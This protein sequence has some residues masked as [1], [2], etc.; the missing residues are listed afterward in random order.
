MKSNTNTKD[1]FYF[2]KNNILM[3]KRLNE[4]NSLEHVLKEFII[5][6]KLQKGMNEVLVKQAWQNLMGNG[7]NTYTDE[8]MLKN[9][10]LYVKLS[11]AVLREE[12]NFG[13]QKIISL[14]NEELKEEIVTQLILR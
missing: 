3:A 4:E 5:E 13:K 14:L 6:N 9:N 2:L 10:T 1:Q 11:S 8:I 12:L 7:V